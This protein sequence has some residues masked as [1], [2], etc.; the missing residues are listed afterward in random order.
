MIVLRNPVSKEFDISKAI[1]QEM[2]F[3][4]CSSEGLRFEH[5]SVSNYYDFTF[6]ILIILPGALGIELTLRD[7]N[8]ETKNRNVR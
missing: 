1:S 8:T 5:N 4:Y 6:E 3:D 2:A 7:W